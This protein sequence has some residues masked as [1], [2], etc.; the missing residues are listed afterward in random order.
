MTAKLKRPNGHP[1][2]N[3][4]I[5]ALERLLRVFNLERM[6]YLAFGLVSLVIFAI[7]GFRLTTGGQIDKELLSWM[8]G[9]TGVAAASSA[10]VVFFLGKAFGLVEALIKDGLREVRDEEQ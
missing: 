4:V 3:E 9:S 6:L 2:L 5:S 7:A 1:S 10:R 8:L